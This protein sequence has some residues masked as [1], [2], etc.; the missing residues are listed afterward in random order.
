MAIDAISQY[1]KGV[2]GRATIQLGEDVTKA[3]LLKTT[4]YD[5]YLIDLALTGKAD[6][7]QQLYYSGYDGG[8]F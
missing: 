8:N 1:L 7:D 2:M 4:G 6:S 3:S 5:Y